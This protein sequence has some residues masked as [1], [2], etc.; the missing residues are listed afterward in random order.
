MKRLFEIDFMHCSRR[1]LILFVTVANIIGWLAIIGGTWG[2]CML[3]E[4]WTA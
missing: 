1:W 3:I 4:W 2:I